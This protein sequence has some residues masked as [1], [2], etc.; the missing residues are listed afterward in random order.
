MSDRH[1]KPPS[2]TGVNGGKDSRGRF[3]PGNA[4]GRG[5][6]HRGKRA[7][8]Q[9]AVTRIVTAD[10]IAEI[11][12]ALIEKAKQG[13]VMAAREVFDRVFGRPVASVEFDGDAVGIVGLQ[14]TYADDWWGSKEAADAALS[15]EPSQN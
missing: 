15:R 2:A 11:I 7:M 10:D 9:A 13:D 1:P 4:Y 3:A 8:L 12:A 5:D 6:P 14:I